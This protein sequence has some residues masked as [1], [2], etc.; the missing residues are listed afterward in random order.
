MPPTEAELEFL[1]DQLNHN[2]YLKNYMKD[3]DSKISKILDKEPAIDKFGLRAPM[4]EKLVQYSPTRQAK[5]GKEIEAQQKIELQMS[6]SLSLSPGRKMRENLR[7]ECLQNLK[8]NTP[9][10]GIK[11]RDIFTHSNLEKRKRQQ[12]QSLE[13]RTKMKNYERFLKYS[14]VEHL[15][16]EQKKIYK[17]DEVKQQARQRKAELSARS[18]AREELLMQAS[19][20]GGA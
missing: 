8:E 6:D 13:T 4:M 18:K 14:G 20:D 7:L 10:P 12:Q 17:F 2:K 15:S 5:Q 16:P 9:N 19:I 3:W 11:I 1:R